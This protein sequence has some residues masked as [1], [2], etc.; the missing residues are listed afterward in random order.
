MCFA[1][2]NVFS[3]TIPCMLL[4]QSNIDKK[5]DLLSSQINCM[6]WDSDVN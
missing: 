2:R 1:M 6:D 4:Y 5:Y 3:D